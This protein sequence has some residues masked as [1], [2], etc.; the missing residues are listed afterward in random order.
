MKNLTIFLFV[1]TLCLFGHV[2]SAG[3]KIMNELKMNK[4]LLMKCYSKNDVLGPKK[5]PNGGSYT[6]YFKRNIFGRTRFMCTL[7]Q[8]PK[9]KLTQKFRAFKVKGLWEWRAREDGIYLRRK[10]HGKT[11]DDSTKNLHKELH[12]E[13]DWITKKV[14]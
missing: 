5:I 10:S 1:L 11:F 12:K 4:T 9:F 3:I 7:L 13:F 6:N 14:S 2:S 8:G